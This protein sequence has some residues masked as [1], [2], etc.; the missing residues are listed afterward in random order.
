MMFGNKQK[1]IHTLDSNNLIT[2]CLKII[3]IKNDNF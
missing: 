1:S 3:Y 2:K